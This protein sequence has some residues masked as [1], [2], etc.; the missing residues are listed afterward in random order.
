VAIEI[1][2]CDRRSGRDGPDRRTRRGS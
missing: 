1:G 2:R